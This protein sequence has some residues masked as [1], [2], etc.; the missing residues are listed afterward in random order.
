MPSLEF[1]FDFGS[2]N[3]Y[4]AHQAIQQIEARL[5]VR[6]DYVPILLGGVF[7][8]TNNLPPMVSMEGILNKGDYM[9]V[10]TRRFLK[11][12]SLQPYTFNPHFPVNT[13]HLMRGAVYAK[14]TDYFD[15]YMD[16]MCRHMWQ[17][18]KNM[19]DLEVF[20]GTLENSGLPADEI[21]E[22]IGQPDVK[23]TL[24]SNTEESVRRGNFGAPTFFVDD[25]IFFGKN[26]LAEVEAWFVQESDADKH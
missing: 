7:K 23:S 17:E 5:G 10:E 24:I 15:T 1:H 20:K 4:L 26:T 8:A 2:P 16:E 19:A 14:N 21:L 11:Q 13:L 22:G 6:F 9:Q 18:P 3:V 12:Y 25:E